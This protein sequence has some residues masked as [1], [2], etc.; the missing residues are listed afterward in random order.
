MLVE[1]KDIVTWGGTDGEEQNFYLDGY[2]TKGQG[3]GARTGRGRAE[4]N[5]VDEES[6]GGV[7]QEAEGVRRGVSSVRCYRSW[8]SGVRKT[9]GLHGQVLAGPFFVITALL[10]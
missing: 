5:P 4:S 10:R 1:A 7:S 2:G 8:R 3:H 6:G 9:R